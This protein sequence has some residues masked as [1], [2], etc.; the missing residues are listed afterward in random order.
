M[1]HVKKATYE[2]NN[3]NGEDKTRYITFMILV[4]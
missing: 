4:V 1:R 2:I 3:T